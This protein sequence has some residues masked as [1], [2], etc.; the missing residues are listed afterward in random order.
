[1]STES[2]SGYSRKNPFPATLTVNRKLTAEGSN[3]DTRHFE[4]TLAGSGLDY[5]V[6]DSL[7]VFPSNDPALV[8]QLLKTLGFQGDEI[9]P[10]ADKVPVPIAEALSKS[11]IITAPDKKLLG[12][13][14][15]KDSS[16]AFLKDF[17]DPAYKTS[18]DEYL[19][20]RDV[21]D[22]LLE[23]TAAKFTPEEFV[24]NLRKLQPRLYSIASSRRV[25]GENVHLTVAVVRYT[26]HNRARAGVASSFLAERADGEGAVPVFY[27]TA[28]HFRV[29]EDPST[30]MI[31]VGPG[32]GIAPFRA[33]LQE[34]A[35]TG[36]SGKN[37]LFFGEQQ[38]KSDFFY[39]DEFEG[40][41]T[42][43]VLSKFTTAFSRDQ[44]E[45]IYVQHRMLE[46]AKEFYDYLESGAIFYV[47][48]DASRM[49]KDVDTAMH[50][51]VEQVGGKTAD[52]AKEY[53]DALKKDKRYRKDV[54]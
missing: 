50:Q 54:Y 44:A 19:W 4:I 31:M 9:V 35:A 51:I 47:C 39:K 45:K 40:Y 17:L 29:P 7:G 21:L 52:Q 32:T 3:K 16:A 41:Q 46:H 22:P 33:M 30:A 18:L 8:E 13:I 1:M 5:E 11:Y 10:N 12:A 42:Q 34:R 25:V 15:E 53:I 24:A 26:A 23:F 2:A 49:A 28:K 6:G 36:A 38:A 27:H 43:G 14:A 20:G 48:G 37:W